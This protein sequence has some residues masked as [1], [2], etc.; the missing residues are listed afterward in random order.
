MLA[1]SLYHLE[2][3]PLQEAQK[4]PLIFGGPC[5]RPAGHCTE[6]QRSAELFELVHPRDEQEQTSPGR[7]L[8]A[9]RAERKLGIKIIKTILFPGIFR[10]SEAYPN[11]KVLILQ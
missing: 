6:R 10:P 11:Y 1:L 7:D 4:R 5:S 2:E 9:D 3:I 8:L